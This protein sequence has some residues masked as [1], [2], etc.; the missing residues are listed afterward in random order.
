MNDEIERHGVTDS[1]DHDR[2]AIALLEQVFVNPEPV[3]PVNLFVNESRRWFP[4]RNL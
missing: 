1:V 2:A 4:R 3:G